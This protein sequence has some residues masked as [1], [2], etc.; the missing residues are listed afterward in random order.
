[1]G[2]RFDVEVRITA[3]VTISSFLLYSKVRTIPSR[4]LLVMKWM[5]AHDFWDVCRPS[6]PSVPRARTRSMILS[7]PSG[8]KRDDWEEIC[9]ISKHFYAAYRTHQAKTVQ[10]QNSFINNSYT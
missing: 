10:P 5:D 2:K 7:E 6:V 3:I 1:M 4:F 8:S 9:A